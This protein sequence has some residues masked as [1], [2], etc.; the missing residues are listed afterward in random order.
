MPNRRASPIKIICKF[1]ISFG[2]TSKYN[3][4]WYNFI[5]VGPNGQARQVLGDFG[6]PD[7]SKLQG[8]KVIV[9]TDE[10]GV[11]NERSASVLGQHLGDLAQKPSFAPLHI[12]RWDNDLFNKHKEQIIVDVE[13]NVIDTMQEKYTIVCS[14][15]Q[16][17][18]F[19][20][21]SQNL[22]FLAK[23][24]NLQEIGS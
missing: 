5:H 2:D 11:P 24:Y 13:V 10:N 20:L 7:L 8:G 4:K 16:L 19:S 21:Y 17:F 15:H 18:T 9:G 6:V 23:R 14:D 1:D 3:V 12:P 22:S